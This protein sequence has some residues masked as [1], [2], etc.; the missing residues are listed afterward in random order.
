[1]FKKLNLNSLDWA[2]GIFLLIM[3]AGIVF[4]MPGKI[5]HSAIHG[6]LLKQIWEDIIHFESYI[7]IFTFGFI[8]LIWVETLKSFQSVKINFIQTMTLLLIY[9]GIYL[10]AILIGLSLFSWIVK[11]VSEGWKGSMVDTVSLAPF[12]FWGCPIFFWYWYHAN[13]SDLN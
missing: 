6:K 2:E 3:C 4:F 8:G 10:I 7:K 13:K 1:M 12:I 5:E 11:R 9:F